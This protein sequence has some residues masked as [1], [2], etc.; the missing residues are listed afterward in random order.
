M[1]QEFSGEIWQVIEMLEEARQKVE[2]VCRRM[3]D[4]RVR[5]VLVDAESDIDLVGLELFELVQK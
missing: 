2:D 5:R 4:G 1:E 3:D